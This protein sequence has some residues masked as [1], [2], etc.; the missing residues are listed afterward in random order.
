MDAI[1]CEGKEMKTRFLPDICPNKVAV[2][3]QG[4][5]RLDTYLLP[6]IE[7]SCESLKIPCVAGGIVISRGVLILLTCSLPSPRLRRQ[8]RPYGILPATQASVKSVR[9]F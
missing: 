7:G 3:F 1:R 5:E 6:I 8:K 9:N 4:A 2:Y